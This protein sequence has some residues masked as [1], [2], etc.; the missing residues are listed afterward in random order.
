VR[1]FAEAL[2][3]LGIALG[4]A[5]PARSAE[6]RI[7]LKGGVSYV[8]PARPTEK[9]GRYVFRAADGTLMSIRKADV[10]AVRPVSAGVKI[11]KTEVLGLTSPAAAARNQKAVADELRQR[12]GNPMFRQDAYRPGV[13]VP[14]PEGSH[15]YVVGKTFAYPPSGAVYEGPAPT[16]VPE[17]DAPKVQT[18]P[19]APPTSQEPPPPPR[20]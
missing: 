16:N 3:A 14:Y 11:T 9:A 12:R 5:A 18:P 2:A 10:A 13:G 15:D 4:V 17:G 20:G 6:F 19:P 7:E 8:T 1:R